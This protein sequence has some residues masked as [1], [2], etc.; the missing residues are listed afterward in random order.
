MPDPVDNIQDE[1]LVL[2]VSPSDLTNHDGMSSGGTAGIVLVSF[3]AGA[4]A[5]LY[6]NRRRKRRRRMSA[7]SYEGVATNMDVDDDFVP[8]PRSRFGIFRSRHIPEMKAFGD[9]TYRDEKDTQCNYRDE[10]DEEAY[11]SGN[12][13][14]TYY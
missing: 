2:E 1:V 9:A 8:T 13:L 10:P 11:N 5:M 3:A 14:R 12:F 7:S 6:G 4:L